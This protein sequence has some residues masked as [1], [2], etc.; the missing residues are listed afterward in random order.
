M[1]EQVTFPHS[2]S[3]H[4]WQDEQGTGGRRQERNEMEQLLWCQTPNP[5]EWTLQSPWT[6]HVFCCQLLVP[7]KALPIPLLFCFLAKA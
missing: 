4:G 2:L 7:K 3:S 1:G 5:T 6:L